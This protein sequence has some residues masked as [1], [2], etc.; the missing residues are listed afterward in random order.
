MRGRAGQAA[1]GQAAILVLDGL[2]VA[3]ERRL[4]HGQFL[5]LL[6][7]VAE[8]E[9]GS[10][11]QVERHFIGKVVGKV[12]QAAGRRQLRLG[13]RTVLEPRA[14]LTENGVQIGAPDIAPVEKAERG[15]CAPPN[16]KNLLPDNQ[17]CTPTN[18]KAVGLVHRN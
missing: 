6:I 1:A 12:Q 5:Q 9:R 10:E 2:A 13:L 3:A 17:S 14:E 16:R 8:A 18:H 7:A 4:Q 11:L 15:S